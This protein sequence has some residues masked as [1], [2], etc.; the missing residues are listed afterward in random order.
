MKKPRFVSAI[1]FGAL[2]A[3]QVLLMQYILLAAPL[4]NITVGFMLEAAMILVFFAACIYNLKAK[5]S[6]SAENK[7]AVAGAAILYL[8]FSAF[9][10]QMQ[11]QIGSLSL[12]LFNPAWQQSMVPGM[13]I[14][15]VKLVLFLGAVC[16]MLM[17]PK[18]TEVSVEFDTPVEATE[19][20]GDT[21][22]DE[23]NTVLDEKE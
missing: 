23:I 12:S 13:I 10:F 16:C 8:V 20:L 11:I 2:F 3:V 19:L 21:A 22:T 7:R 5:A 4:T 9:T 15:G 1:L 14:C 17:E 6:V 18:V